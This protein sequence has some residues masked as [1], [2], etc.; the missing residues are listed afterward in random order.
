MIQS[1]VYIFSRFTEEALLFEA[2]ILSVLIAIYLAF[3]VL[4]KRKI[5]SADEQI[6]A[7]LVKQYLN[8]LIGNAMLI[9]TQLFGLLASQGHDSAALQGLLSQLGTSMNAA[10]GAAVAPSATSLATPSSAT[11][12]LPGEASAQLQQLEGK[13]N[14][15]LRVIETLKVEKAKAEQE[16]ATLKTGTG[17]EGSSAA[18]SGDNTELLE[19]I[20]ALEARLAE[21]SVIEDDL[22]NL[23]RLQQENVQLKGMLE[24]KGGDPAAP[25]TA[26]APASTEA[27]T[28]PAAA[29]A[30]EAP[31]TAAAAAVEAAIAT[32]PTEETHSTESAAV[33]AEATLA[34]ETP[35]AAVEPP[36]PEPAASAETPVTTPPP[37]AIAAAEAPPTPSPTATSAAVEAPAPAAAAP[38]PA[39]PTSGGGDDDLIAEFEKMLNS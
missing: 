27:P 14:E 39:K 16:L 34:V 3:W 30:E 35:A 15:Q 10:A 4:K 8:E 21:Y 6:P 9:R 32:P 33:I 13:L 26:A 28:P 11:A 18:P 29:A 5:G 22:A 31:I 7:A 17:T 24:G 25:P 20:K 2:L 37:T 1:W 36:A 19:K 38:A 12:G 23:K